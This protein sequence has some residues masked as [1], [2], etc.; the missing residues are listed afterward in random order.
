[1]DV[2]DW[3]LIIGP[4][5]GVV[6]GGAITGVA[7]YFELRASR[8]FE[9]NKL[10]IN[11]IE[12]LSHEL[13]TLKNAVSKCGET[14]QTVL[15]SGKRGK[16]VQDVYVPHYEHIS[17]SIETIRVLQSNYAESAKPLFEELKN[18][19]NLVIETLY[20]TAFHNSTDVNMQEAIFQLK[21][22]AQELQVA[23]SLTTRSL[24]LKDQ[25]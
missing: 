19:W 14:V 16:E 21:V 3:L 12:E 2:K 10:R 9:L 24:L 23:L 13:G 25:P 6:I 5:V 7:K 8:R 20:S 18:A 4:L 11:K 1:M 15:D 22:K 17:K